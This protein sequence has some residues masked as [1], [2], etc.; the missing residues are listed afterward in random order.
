MKN[1]Y[2]P[3]DKETR[4]TLKSGERVHLYGSVYT[5]R[6]AA[7]K[8][9]TDLIK[10]KKKLPFTLKDQII[11]YVGP[12]PAPTGKVIGSAGPTT[13]SRMDAFTAPLLK[14]GLGG[15][16][17]K[18]RRSKDIR[19]AIKNHQAVYFVAPGGAAALL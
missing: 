15:M 17:G 5:A 9:L 3:L 8:R 13:S 12:T 2:L 18:G 7:H 19:K 1:L 16:I 6:D 14:K 10:K 4:K 11:Y